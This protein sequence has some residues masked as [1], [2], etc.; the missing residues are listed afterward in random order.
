MRELGKALAAWL[1][2]H[3]IETDVAGNSLAAHWTKIHE[4]PPSSGIPPGPPPP[5]IALVALAASA[6]PPPLRRVPTPNMQAPGGGLSRNSDASTRVR[7]WVRAGRSRSAAQILAAA[8]LTVF[9]LFLGDR[10][11]AKPPAGAPL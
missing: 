1:T 5:S 3:G 10:I 8:A 4:H 9:V 11:G 2:C 6:G 7:A